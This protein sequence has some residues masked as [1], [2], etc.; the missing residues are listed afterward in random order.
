M[1]WA[2]RSRVNDNPYEVIG[3]MPQEFFFLPGPD[4]DIWMPAS[5]PPWMRTNF[6]WHNATGRREAEAW[7]DA[8]AGQGGDGGP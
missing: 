6:G 5:F 4:I 8:G 1:S 7:R 3:V 2:A